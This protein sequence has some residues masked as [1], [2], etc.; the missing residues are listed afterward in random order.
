V[1]DDCLGDKGKTT[2]YIYNLRST[3]GLGSFFE[4]PRRQCKGDADFQWRLGF[5]ELA[6]PD[7]FLFPPEFVIDAEV[8]GVGAQIGSVK[9]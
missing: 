7:F 9:L 1:A 3:C 6:P 2:S 5:S 4:S 8:G